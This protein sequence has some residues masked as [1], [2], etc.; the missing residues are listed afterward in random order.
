MKKIIL[1]LL[2]VLTTASAP[3]PAGADVPLP[4][5]TLAGSTKTEFRI[6][7]IR[8]LFCGRTA[9]LIISIAIFTVGFL[10]VIGKLNWGIALFSIAGIVVFYRAEDIARSFQGTMQF[11]LVENP[12]CNCDCPLG[13]NFLME[14]IDS[15]SKLGPLISNIAGNIEHCIPQTGG[16]FGMGLDGAREDFINKLNNDFQ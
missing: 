12:L 13:D 10:M 9:V 16:A 8:R 5:I 7:K 2:I 3:K 11:M 14:A 1:L 6:C 15:P 4:I